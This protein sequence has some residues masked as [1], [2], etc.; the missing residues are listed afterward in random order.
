MGKKVRIS[1]DSVNSYGFRVLTSGMD[2]EQFRRN[3]V[4]LYMH[5]RGQVIG[6]VKN[7]E[8]KDGEVTGE[9]EFDCATELSKRCKAQFEFG[10]LRMVSAGLDVEATDDSPELALPGQTQATVTRC[11]LDEVSVVDIGANDDAIVLTRDGRR[12]SLGA[13]GDN[14]LPPLRK[15]TD[16][17]QKPNNQPKTDMELKDIVL[18]LGLPETATEAEVGARIEALAKA[19]RENENLVR[20]GV[21]NM[22]DTAIGDGRLDKEARETYV[23]LGLEIGLERLGKALGSIARPKE[24]PRTTL[25]SMVH[26]ETEPRKSRYERLSQVPEQELVRLR[27]DEPEEYKRLY[28]EEYGFR[29]S[30]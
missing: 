13:G 9:L 28:E 3:P 2:V 7:L 22:V 12:V 23:G 10:S 25:A 19:E 5:Q 30:I 4:L 21:E 11:R 20:Q 29:P 27:K 1:N 14:P 6:Y 26:T 15:T 18:R 24:M 8:V 16:T 17:D